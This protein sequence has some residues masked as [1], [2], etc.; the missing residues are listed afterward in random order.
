MQGVEKNRIFID[1]EEKQ[2]KGQDQKTQESESA[3]PELILSEGNDLLLTL[4]DAGQDEKGGEI[5]A[6]N[7]PFVIP[8]TDDGES[9]IITRMP[10]WAFCYISDQMAATIGDNQEPLGD[11]GRFFIPRVGVDVAVNYAWE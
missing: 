3:D 11:S 7:E 4:N 1:K 9:F 8:D 10:L 5:S 6:Q 2:E